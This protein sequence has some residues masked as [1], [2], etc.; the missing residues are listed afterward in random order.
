[1]TDEIYR[2]KELNAKRYRCSN[3]GKELDNPHLFENLFLCDV[4]YDKIEKDLGIL[5][6]KE[7][8]IRQQIADEYQELIKKYK[9]YEQDESL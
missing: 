9:H 6:E 7:A 2:Q 1:M 3:C 5:L 4:C 8:Q